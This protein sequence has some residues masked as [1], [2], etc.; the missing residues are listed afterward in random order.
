MMPSRSRNSPP[1]C[2]RSRPAALPCCV[3]LRPAPL[4][5]C[6]QPGPTIAHCS[7]FQCPG[8][9][10]F[11]TRLPTSHVTSVEALLRLAAIVLS[12]RA[13][14]VSQRPPPK[15]HF[16]RH[17]GVQ[18]SL[19]GI[20]RQARSATRAVS[21]ETSTSTCRPGHGVSRETPMPAVPARCASV[22]SHA[23]LERRRREFSARRSLSKRAASVAGG[24]KRPRKRKDAHRAAWRLALRGIR[25][26]PRGDSR[27]VAPVGTR[28][29][30]NAVPAKREQPHESFRRMRRPSPA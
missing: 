23:K 19:P 29:A 7:G 6:A 22:P 12:I 4:G 10:A 30:V 1:C 18:S 3:S 24:H 27:L 28:T 11:G 8:T 26:H 9:P 13:G 14:S 15:G 2:A 20:A 25:E 5:R 17:G 16:G 21:R